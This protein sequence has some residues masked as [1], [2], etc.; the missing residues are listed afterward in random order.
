VIA[1]DLLLDTLPDALVG[2]EAYKRLRLV[3]DQL[4][5]SL[6][7]RIG[8][9]ARLHDDPRVDL[10][11]LAADAAQLEVLA[12]TH[13]PGGLGADLL[14]HPAWQGVARLAR[15]SL[16]LLECGGPL[17]AP[18]WL[19]LDADPLRPGPP[20]PGVFTA[21]APAPNSASAARWNVSG[22]V[23]EILAM[24]ADGGP[25]PEVTEQVRRVASGLSVRRLG[26]TPG[27][28]AATVRLYCAVEEPERLVKTLTRCGW[29]GPAAELA[30]WSARCA[31]WVDTVHVALDV[32]AER[33]EPQVGLAL[34][35]GGTPQP[36][37]DAR[38]PALFEALH[39]EGLC[40]RAKADA[41]GTLGCRYEAR[42]DAGTEPRQYRQGLHHLKL[43]VARDASV[44]AKAYFGGYEV[45]E[46]RG[47]P[48]GYHGLL[49]AGL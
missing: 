1:L 32:G 15:R 29:I 10:M 14:T 20:D 12:G 48:A 39:A 45:T 26:L 43:T 42:G 5:D 16:R 28:P 34:S 31:D 6:S 38:W 49:T 18:L 25:A 41:L 13:G 30:R 7:R 37:G 36:R 2:E 46:G 11:V 40:T 17:P 8:L 9:E 47:S 22:T 27:R 19:E 23:A 44:T 35:L 3:G 33:I 21:A 24:A 4:P